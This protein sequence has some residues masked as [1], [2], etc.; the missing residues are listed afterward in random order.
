MRTEPGGP[1]HFEVAGDDGVFHPAAAALDGSA[2]LLRSE[3]VAAPRSVRYC[4]AAAAIG[5][6]WDAHGLPVVPFVAAVD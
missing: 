1:R 4:H 2:V 3:R 6:L 5:D